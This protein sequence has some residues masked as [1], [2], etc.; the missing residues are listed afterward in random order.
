LNNDPRF[1]AASA[2][3]AIEPIGR[4]HRVVQGHDHADPRRGGGNSNPVETHLVVM[5]RDRPLAHPA[6]GRST[7]GARAGRPV[8]C[9]NDWP[10]W[11][12]KRWRAF[13]GP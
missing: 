5:G 7:T 9:A 11:I 3:Y 6:E 1:P 8:R 2:S 4:E 10:G 13:R 12:S